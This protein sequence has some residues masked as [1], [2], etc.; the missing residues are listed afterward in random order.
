MGLLKW[1]RSQVRA[2][3]IHMDMTWKLELALVSCALLGLR[4]GFDYDH[5]AAISDIT[6]V[7]RSWRQ[8]MRLG[9]TYALGH[10]LTVVALGAAVIM[11]HI[12]LPARL[13][14]WTER[15]IGATLIVLGIGVLGSMLRQPHAHTAIQSR[16]AILIGGLN[17]A[18]WRLRKIFRPETPKPDRFR[19]ELH[20]R[21]GLRHRRAAWAGRRNSQ[22]ADALS[23]DGEPRR[24]HSRLSRAGCVRPRAGGDEYADDRVDRR[25]L[26][27]QFSSAP[28]MPLDRGRRRRVQ[29]HHRD[30]LPARR[31]GQ[32]APSRELELGARPS[33]PNRGA[34]G[35]FQPEASYL[36]RCEGSAPFS[37]S[38]FSRPLLP[39]TCWATC[40]SNCFGA[41]I[42]MAPLYGGGALLVREAVRRTHRG[43]AERAAAGACVWNL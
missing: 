23:A 14:A 11:L 31:F 7:Q 18:W 13:D 26:R 4:H 6:A 21:L 3:S 15:L 25:H 1:W 30:H 36:S 34:Q 33:C 19:V 10:A 17:W 16:L 24:H 2:L 27:R 40:L 37:D 29:L 28:S 22:P 8:G 38:S 20:R 39:N 41:M 35:T 42:V 32:I 12:P 9:V 43:W 5:L